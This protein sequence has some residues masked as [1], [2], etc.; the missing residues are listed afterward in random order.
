MKSKSFLSCFIVVVC[1]TF[2][3]GA[4]ATLNSR[5]MAWASALL[6]VTLTSRSYSDPLPINIFDAQYT[7]SVSTSSWIIG[8]GETTDS[9]TLF[10]L[11]PISDLMYHSVSGQLE[12][13]ANVGL[14]DIS[15]FTAAD[16]LHDPLRS[17]SVASAQSEIWFSPLTSQTTTV[18]LQFSGW[19][20]WYYS[21]GSVSLLDVTSG[22]EVWNYGW[23]SYVS[24]TVPWEPTGGNPSMTA[25]LTLDTDFIA[26]DTYELNMYTH[27]DSTPPDSEQI[28]IQ[29][30]GLEPIPEPSTSILFGLGS[31][32]LA[33]VHRRRQVNG[34][35]LWAASFGPPQP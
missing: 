8:G 34:G 4:K 18:N 16:G 9:R 33:M 20:Q 23:N 2:K 11:V 7:T 3:L 14:F 22:D 28:L 19:S 27:T 10:S 30:F 13:E 26:A 1:S 15:A 35:C 24:G 31:F 32:A 5:I 17:G 21:E 25:S 12:A 6:T 29:L